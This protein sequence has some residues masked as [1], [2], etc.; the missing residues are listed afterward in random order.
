MDDELDIKSG[1]DVAVVC[2]TDRKLELDC[3]RGERERER[4]RKDPRNGG[5]IEWNIVVTGHKV[6]EF[7]GYS[8]ESMR[9][10]FSLPWK[11]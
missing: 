7:I 11:E 10:S 6:Y 8:R 4:E 5:H 1:D 3:R 9:Y 2:L